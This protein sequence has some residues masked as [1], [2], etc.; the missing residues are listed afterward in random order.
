MAGALRAIS[1][2]NPPSLG[3][4]GTGRAGMTRALA[5]ICLSNFFAASASR[6]TD[7]VLPLIAAD[8]NVDVQAAALLATAFALPWVIA[9]PIFGPLGDLIGKTRVI[10]VNLIILLASTLVGAVTK[11]FTS[12]FLSRVAAGIA[13]AGVMPVGFAL[14]G[15]LTPPSERQVSIGRVVG[16]AMAGQL[17]GAVVAGLLGD[18]VGWRGVFFG[19]ACGLVFSTVIVFAGLRHV[20]VPRSNAVDLATVLANYRTIFA[21]PLAKVCFAAVFFEGIAIYGVMPYIA[22]L[23]TTIG[24]T[25]AVIA[26]AVIAG[27]AVGGVAYSL[28]V[29]IVIGRLEPRR[30]MWMGAALGAAALATVGLR[31]PWQMQMAALT[32]F[33]FGSYMLHNC[34]QVK[35]LDL[36]PSARGSSV[37]MHA[38][39]FFMGQALG[40]VLFGLALPSAGAFL[41]TAAAGVL[42]LAIGIV[43]GRLLY[44]RTLAA[45]A[46]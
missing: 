20:A 42:L 1:P 4:G 45:D 15:D 14:S 24:E 29:P 30:I 36:A 35:M 31:P 6:I 12:L 32:V 5:V 19:A 18:V 17:L 11:D 38:S 37:A 41:T 8:L 9:Q 13:T 46:R 21:N 26:G 3:Q 10:R 23:L 28:L 40:P 27:F 7:P 33:G 43:S 2:C 34:I 44:P 25:R 22:P 16:S 39:S